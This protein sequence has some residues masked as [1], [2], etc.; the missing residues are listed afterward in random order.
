MMTSVA[1][2]SEAATSDSTADGV[3]LA[4]SLSVALGLGLTCLA[5]GAAVSSLRTGA[6]CSG[7]LPSAGSSIQ[8]EIFPSP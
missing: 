3:G 6:G 5:P 4:A 7:S 1:S 2:V 8:R